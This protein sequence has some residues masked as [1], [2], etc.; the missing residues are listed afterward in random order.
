MT[1]QEVTL[2]N[3]SRALL[4][5]K[6]GSKEKRP[7]NIGGALYRMLNRIINSR[8]S[9]AISHLLTPLQYA[10]GV[11]GGTDKMAAIVDTLMQEETH[12]II[13]IDL[14]N[15]FNLIPRSRV[16]DAILKMCPILARHFSITHRGSSHA[17]LS[18]GKKLGDSSR[19][20]R[21][22]DP[23]AGT[24][25]CL[26]IHDLLVEAKNL[27]AEKV[28]PERVSAVVAYAD[29]AYFMAPRECTQP[30]PTHPNGLPLLVK[31]I[32]DIFSDAGVQ[33][34]ADK[35]KIYS[36]DP[37]SPHNFVQVEG[38]EDVEQQQQRR[39]DEIG[40]KCVGIPI[41]RPEFVQ[42]MVNELFDSMSTII[43]GDSAQSRF[44]YQRAQGN[45]QLRKQDIF[46][47]LN[48]CV[49]AR[50]V[51]LMRNID[52]TITIP[53]LELFDKRMTDCLMIL[54][55]MDPKDVNS[56]E[57]FELIR[58]L[59]RFLRGLGIRKLTAFD[60]AFV[61][62]QYNQCT[63]AVRAFMAQQVPTELFSGPD[64]D[65][66]TLHNKLLGARDV[67]IV[68]PNCPDRELFLNDSN[69]FVLSLL[70]KHVVEDI[71]K[72]LIDQGKR[73]AA[74]IWLSGTYNQAAAFLDYHGGNDY[75]QTLFDGQF[76]QYTHIWCAL[77]PHSRNVLPMVCA[78]N[79]PLDHSPWHSLVCKQASGY[80][81]VCTSLWCTLSTTIFGN[82]VNWI[83]E[84]AIS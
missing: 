20:V 4:I 76:T 62:G 43:D 30:D 8:V 84:G 19:G 59:P 58:S 45:L 67:V 71:R 27:V 34:N 33:V 83:L 31:Q 77:P 12:D 28:G 14:K 47:I 23:L 70:Y 81:L 55:D 37:A 72:E 9:P 48:F 3:A 64:A 26:G 68:A 22:G 38:G 73:S 1:P 74:A 50:P 46:A 56:R 21:Q 24:L 13:S 51:Y 39:Y 78:C 79:V 15:A 54:L 66:V 2:W 36:N 11:P 63:E 32:L 75:R 5:P 82:L 41:G 69:T 57:L 7:L 17:F 35:T 40:F 65:V 18:N 16:Y 25:F 61:Q 60:G 44:L 52:P 53:A 42:K 49:S 6:P 80:R 10:I 29:D